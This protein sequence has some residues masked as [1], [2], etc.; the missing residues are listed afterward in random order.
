[1]QLKGKVRDILNRRKGVV[2]TKG[3]KVDWE[4][5]VARFFKKLFGKKGGK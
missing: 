4:Y 1:L 2:L 5:S 3:F